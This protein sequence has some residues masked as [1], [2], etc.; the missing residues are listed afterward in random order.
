MVVTG[1]LPPLDPKTPYTASRLAVFEDGTTM[2]VLT[3][4]AEQK[5]GTIS[6]GL[7][8]FWLDGDPSHEHVDNVE[9][10]QA[11][12][13]EYR[14]LGLGGPDYLHR[15]QEANRE[16]VREHTRNWHRR[17]RAKRLLASSSR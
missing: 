12:K 5:F 4:L 6:K 8:P 17:R 15:W 2:P 10:A 9:L 7:F 14:R 1:Y 13:R 11:T 3:L 16:R